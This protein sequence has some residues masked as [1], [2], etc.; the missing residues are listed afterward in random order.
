MSLSYTTHTPSKPK[1]QAP[2]LHAL[3][4]HYLKAAKNNRAEA[5]A[6]T[7]NAIF[8]D[9]EL[10]EALAVP[11]VAGAVKQAVGEVIRQD[12]ADVW[13]GP[14]PEAGKRRVKITARINNLLL[15]NFRL[16]TGK[17]LRDATAAEVKEAAMF[18]FKQGSDMMVK[19]RW[20]TAIAKAVPAGEIVGKVLREKQLRT[21]RTK[22]EVA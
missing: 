2:S 6:A 9:N 20:L 17:L 16:P 21:L 1:R 18:Y 13:S 15:M 10:R 14:S 8:A 12:R 5:E 3:A 4:A 22:A 19:Y 7:I 11:L